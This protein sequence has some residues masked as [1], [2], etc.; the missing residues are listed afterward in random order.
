MKK[1][2]KH[3]LH[4][5]FIWTGSIDIVQNLLQFIFTIFFAYLL[6]KA[7]FGLFGMSILTIRLA[8]FIEYGFGNTIIQNQ[9]LT[10]ANV[11]AIFLIYLIINSIIALIIF[12]SASIVSDFFYQE[13]LKLLVQIT[14][15]I[16]LIQTFNFP[17][18][19]LTK[20][21]QH[22][23]KSISILI[24]CIIANIFALYFAYSGYG[25]FSL[26]IRLYISTIIQAV[27]CFYYSKIQIVKPD[28]HRITKI[29]GLSGN[30]FIIKILSYYSNNIIKILTGKFLGPDALGI[31]NISYDLAIIPAKKLQ[32]TFSSVLLPGF[33]MIQ[34]NYEK[35]Q[36]NYMN[37][38]N[39][40]IIIYVPFLLILSGSAENII[41]TFYGNKWINASES[42]S[43]LILSGAIIGCGELLKS[44]ILAKGHTEIL[45]TS[46]IIRL[47]T[48]VSVMLLL[49][50]QYGLTGLIIGFLLGSAISLVYEA[51]IFDKTFKNNST[52]FKKNY[53]TLL[54]SI[55]LQFI[56]SW[57]GNKLNLHHSFELI[58]QF[59]SS[60][61]VL[62]VLS[63]IFNIST[64]QNLITQIRSVK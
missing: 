52:F 53:R 22:K 41:L 3:K 64:L 12:F 24:S 38:M 9:S 44:F 50:E 18:F 49:L 11:S 33:S 40:I 48:S 42:L 19:I 27:L 5:A 15:F 20:Q 2:I 60:F 35:F 14:S 10:N 58:I 55:L 17:Q 4:K 45:F 23:Y 36:I 8:G 7:E 21:L 46:I 57:V 59:T 56:A 39:S 54:I 16:I 26:I 28:F 13:N 34:N 43:L 63:Y 47:F 37:I 6:T 51:L 30:L 61:T 31:L 62:L 25:A 32:S 29:L 1:S